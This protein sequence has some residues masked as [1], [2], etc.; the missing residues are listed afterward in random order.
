MNWKGCGGKRSWPNLRYCP[1]ICLEGL[2]RN[3]NKVR[4]VALRDEIWTKDLQN[5]KQKRFLL[6]L[7]D[8]NV[9]YM[10][11]NVWH[12]VYWMPVL[13]LRFPSNLTP[14]HTTTRNSQN[15]PARA[16]QSRKQR[17]IDIESVGNGVE[18]RATHFVTVTATKISLNRVNFIFNF[19]YLLDCTCPHILKAVQ[20]FSSSNE[21][22][23]I[24]YS[25]ALI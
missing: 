9:R 5:M 18:F 7:W 1:R 17:A 22:K 11:N 4:L 6:L 15:V 20:K 3:K 12:A 13:C 24:P 10:C 8:V 2:R 21:T 19:R 16:G 23:I 14:A 25:R